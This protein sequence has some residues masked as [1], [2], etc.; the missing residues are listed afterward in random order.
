MQRYVRTSTFTIRAFL[1]IP[2][3]KVNQTSG[4]TLASQAPFSRA[5]AAVQ[6]LPS[7]FS[8]TVLCFTKAT[9]PAPSAKHLINANP[10]TK[11]HYKA[12]LPRIEHCGLAAR[13]L[14]ATFHQPADNDLF[15]C[16]ENLAQGRDQW[17]TEHEVNYCCHLVNMDNMFCAAWDKHHDLLCPAELSV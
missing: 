11:M 8:G 1:L 7:V 3:F 2:Q 5:A 6:H 13:G 9:S 14:H 15:R 4:I 16:A 10:N 17:L 12:Q